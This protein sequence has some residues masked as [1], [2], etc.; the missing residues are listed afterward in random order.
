LYLTCVAGDSFSFFLLQNFYGFRKIKSDPLRLRDAVSDSETKYWKF[1]HEKFQRGRPDLLSEIRKSNHM[2]AADKKEVDCLRSEV[3]ELRS[4][5]VSMAKDMEKLTALLQTAAT[6]ASPVV[7]DATGPSSKKRKINLLPSPVGSCQATAITPDPM[8]VTSAGDSPE[9][10]GPSATHLSMPKI[11]PMPSPSKLT[12][13]SIRDESLA[14]LSA[15]D[16][17]IL[18]SLFSLE[19]S[20]TTFPADDDDDDPILIGAVDDAAPEDPI[21]EVDD[22]AEVEYRAMPTSAID[23]TNSNNNS[24]L[25][26]AELVQKMK[27]SLALLP[28]NLQKLF[29]ERMVA[30]TTNPAAFQT[31]VEAVNALAVS[32]A[33]EARRRRNFAPTSK[34]TAELATAALGSFLSRYQGSSVSP[35]DVSSNM[36]AIDPLLV[37]D[38]PLPVFPLDA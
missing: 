30:L 26:D 20:S 4:R 7:T 5:V 32:A 15:V 33:E 19:P 37:D 10:V 14:S 22:E 36:D 24:G 34:Q 21:Y 1:R 16:E 11:P 25:V 29:V 27:D 18:T 9:V 8:P 23:N 17:E 12:S 2:E 35:A 6:A 38:E 13:S 28:K 31:Q 3:Q